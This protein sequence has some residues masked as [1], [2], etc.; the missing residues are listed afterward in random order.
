MEFFDKH[1]ICH[2]CEPHSEQS[3]VHSCAKFAQIKAGIWHLRQSDIRHVWRNHYNW[4]VHCHLSRADNLLPISAGKVPNIGCRICRSHL[5]RA[6][7]TYTSNI[8]NPS[9]VRVACAPRNSNRLAIIN[10]RARNG[11]CTHWI[12]KHWWWH[13]WRN[14]VRV[15]ACHPRWANRLRHNTVWIYTRR[16]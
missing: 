15:G 3:K 5:H 10:D 13:I 4:W 16:A 8:F 9:C 6:V 14:T 2:E 7:H 11:K 12:Y 1:Q